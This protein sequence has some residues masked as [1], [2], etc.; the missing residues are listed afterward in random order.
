MS[1]ETTVITILVDNRGAPGLVTEHGLSLH[2]RTAGHNLLFDTGQSDACTIN[3][4]ILGLDLG[5]IDAIVLSHGHY[6]HTGG[7]AQVLGL[8]RRAEMYCHPAA[9]SPR[10][11]VRDHQPKP[12]HMPRPSMAALDRLPEERLHWVQQSMQLAATIGLSG[13]IPR[14]TAC[15]DTG[16]P[17]FLDTGGQRPDPIDDDLA[18]WIDTPTGLVVCVGCAH[19]GLVNTLVQ[20]Q[21]LTGGR[22]IRAVI[23]GFHLLSANERRL[24]AT[25]DALRTLA[26]EAIIPCH[27]TGEA[28]VAAL[29][30][31]FGERCHP[32]HAGLRCQYGA[33]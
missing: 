11:A 33:G 1:T 8:A 6:D 10:Y 16:G 21:R 31:A 14:Q 15:E 4:R 20:V 17:F 28:A 30:A 7:L 5:E 2:I 13:P 25:I 22:P 29:S 24:R 19:A 32:G 3:S 12:L 26:P 23:G 9:V 27:C 18:L